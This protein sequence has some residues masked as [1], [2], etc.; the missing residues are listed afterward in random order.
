MALSGH[1]AGL[2]AWTGDESGMYCPLIVCLAVGSA[3][4]SSRGQGLAAR[5][6]GPHL[7]SRCSWGR[8]RGQGRHGTR[9]PPGPRGTHLVL[10]QVP[11]VQRLLGSILGDGRSVGSPAPQPS[12]R[13]VH[14]AAQLTPLP[15]SPCC[16]RCPGAGRPRCRTAAGAPAGPY[17]LQIVGGSGCRLAPHLSAPSR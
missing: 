7:R 4:P 12:P 17:T 6:P 13:P 9:C 5:A 16:R 11:P 10:D 8:G 15:S 1:P 3:L 14:P 2:G